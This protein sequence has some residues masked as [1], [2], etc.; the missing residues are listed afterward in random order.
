MNRYSRNGRIR[1]LYRL[2]NR[3]PSGND[4]Y[5]HRS[6]GAILLLY[7]RFSFGYGHRDRDTSP[8][9]SYMFPDP[10]RSSNIGGT[11]SPMT[12]LS[13]LNV[14]ILYSL[15]RGFFHTGGRALLQRRESCYRGGSQSNKHRVISSYD[16]YT[17]CLHGYR[18][19]ILKTVI[20][21]NNMI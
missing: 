18:C 2:S 7:R 11:S 14:H 16:L 1:P 6:Y 13:I 21:Q 8:N 17:S 9:V 5:T 15:Q 3:Q 10:A 20:K 12:T 4:P 19:E